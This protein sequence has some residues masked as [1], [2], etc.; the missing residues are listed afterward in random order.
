MND[1]INPAHYDGDACMHAIAHVTGAMPGATAFCV[2]QAIKYLWRAGRKASESA[3]DDARK[4]LWYLDWLEALQREQPKRF[5][6]FWRE[7]TII[8][9]LREI[10]RSDTEHRSDRLREALEVW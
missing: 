4:A 5:V 1:K 3:E 6:I 10:A 7:H 2:G 9:K 8:D